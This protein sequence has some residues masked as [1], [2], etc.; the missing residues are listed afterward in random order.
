[1]TLV[2]ICGSLEEGRDGVGDYTRRLAC[3]FVKKGFCVLVLALNDRY[4][5]PHCCHS[6]T[7]PHLLLSQA[8]SCVRYSDKTPW[9]ARASHLNSL[10][11]ES[12]PDWVSLQY[13]PY[14]Y[15]KYGLPWKFTF[16]LLFLSGGF[17]WHIMFHELWI[18][19]K[20][21]P[22]RILIGL[23]QKT[24]IKAT[25]LITKPCVVHSTI[26][27]YVNRL[28]RLGTSASI[29]P[30]HSN[31]DHSKGM[32]IGTRQ[33]SSWSFIFF[34]SLDSQWSSEPFFHYA[35][36]ARQA[37]GIQKCLFIRVGKADHRVNEIWKTMCSAGSRYGAFSF[38][39]LGALP[40]CEVSTIMHSANFGI[41]M[42]P[43]QWI[44][45]SGSVAAMLEH[46]LPVIVPEYDW[47]IGI[48]KCYFLYY[49]S[50][51]FIDSSLPD[52]L[53]HAVKSAP[54]STLSYP[55]SRLTWLFYSIRA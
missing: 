34:G 19:G 50:L 43:I 36:R 12:A 5:T 24:L 15:S 35:E 47:H 21:N 49:R 38:T 17:N 10:L 46:G 32:T 28:R 30:L 13:V 42:C 9:H 4:V 7:P 29:L 31:I 8:Y 16:W 51:L 53:L 52:K 44:G 2:F 3:G 54:I 23:I 18:G 11:S 6:I 41:S 25:L 48:D 26:E 22:K 40:E 27:P 14:S 33:L 20:R 37:A 39:D 45:K 1:V 55:L